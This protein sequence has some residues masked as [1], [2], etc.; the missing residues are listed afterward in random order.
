MRSIVTKAKALLILIVLLVPTNAAR[1]AAGQPGTFQFGYGARVSLE[2]PALDATLRIIAETG[3]DWIA[4][5]YVW[6]NHQPQRDTPPPWEQ[7][8]PLMQVAKEQ[9]IAVMLSITACPPWAKGESGPSPHETTNL[10]L[11]LLER[12]PHSL[13][14]VELFPGPNTVQGWG[15]D[16]NPADYASLLHYIHKVLQA[17]ALNVEIIVGG[18]MPLLEGESAPS[19]MHDVD[20]LHGLYKAQAAAQMPVIGLRLPHPIGQPSQSHSPQGMV[21][22]HYEEIR[23]VMLDNDHRCG[24][25]WITGF[26]WPSD[27]SSDPGQNTLEQ[28]TQWL[29]EAY[30]WMSSQV[31]VGAAFFTP[32]QPNTTTSFDFACSALQSL[33]QQIN[34]DKIPPPSTHRE[35]FA[36]KFFTKVSL[37]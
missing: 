23:Q 5:D 7:L 17:T 31:Y 14:A 1:A 30:F 26:S 29:R 11:T 37:P 32:Y 10:I 9:N 21:I 2:Y 22:R 16:P 34:C 35:K 6:H 27:L 33:Q 13:K 36:P 20:F 24:L 18:L 4:V 12:Y 25:I 19:D 3:F 15:S 8:D 28:Q